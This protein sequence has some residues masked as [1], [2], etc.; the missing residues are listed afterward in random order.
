MN[1]KLLYITLLV[2]LTVSFSAIAQKKVVILHTNDTHSRIEPMPD[3]DS[4]EPNIGGVARREAYINSIRQENKNVLVFDSGD[5]LQGTPYLNLFK[6]KVEVAALNEMKYDAVTLG[7][8]E[9]DYGLEMLETV[10]RQAK[11]PIITTNYDFSDTPLKGL[12]QPYVIFRRDGLKIGVIGIGVNPKGLISSL[13]YGNMKF[14]E[15]ITTASEVAAMLKNKKRCD[16]VI[17]LSHLGY[18]DD[19]KMAEASTHV[20]IILGGHSHTFMMQP[21]TR[22]NAEGKEVTVFHNGDKGLYVGRLDLELERA[23]K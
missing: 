14:L 3:N 9:F 13:N 8:H 4:Y 23:K 22:K 17:C 18:Q 16:I 5:F 20:D 19:I 15:P 21:E 11:F 1:T 7:N 12:T 6:G 10:I 2:S